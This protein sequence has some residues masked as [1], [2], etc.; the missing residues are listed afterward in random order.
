MLMIILNYS[1]DFIIN[2]NYYHTATVQNVFSSSMTVTEN[3]QRYYIMNVNDY[4][5]KGDTVTFSCIYKYEFNKSGFD[6]FY[7]STKSIGY[8]YAN[9]LQLIS[10]SDDIR[11]SLT[12]SLL[13]NNGYYSQLTLLFLYGIKGDST[14]DLYEIISYLG[15]AHLFVVSGF[16]IS[17]LFLF[18]N[19]FLYKSLKHK[20]IV[21]II[22]II[23]I[24]ISLYFIYFP[25]T[26]VRALFCI[27]LA[28]IIKK[29]RIE[30]LSIVALLFFIFN[31]WIMTTSSMILSFGITLS[32]YIY[33]PRFNSILD[34]IC[35]SVMCF[36]IA[37][38]TV[39]TWNNTFNI[40]APFLNIIM[41][42]F[43]TLIYVCSLILLPF[44]NL[45]HMFNWL[46]GIFW[47]TLNIFQFIYIPVELST[48]NFEQQL[49]LV[50]IS[51]IFVHF[52]KDRIVLLNTYFSLAIIF[53]II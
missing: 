19:K 25:L 33:K 6:M 42:P 26:G 45:W 10:R 44:H 22:T 12:N 50:T 9:E 21:I 35:L 3:G 13:E 24:I 38:P 8:G 17:M 20:N 14:K 18:V 52:V 32:I 23:L 39:D 30:S 15:M 16:H 1:N 28:K 51:I 40:L 37:M 47:W 46:F 41:T 36:F 34:D 49:L 11:S 29:D 7:R 27:I 53:I 48:I 4:F 5:I 43:V 31:P 2:N